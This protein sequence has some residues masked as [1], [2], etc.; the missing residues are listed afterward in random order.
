MCICFYFPDF[1]SYHYTAIN[2]ATLSQILVQN[3]IR[4][5]RRKHSDFDSDYELSVHN[6]IQINQKPNYK[7]LRGEKPTQFNLIGI[8]KRL[9]VVS[10]YEGN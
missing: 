5:F 7:N 3:L 10:N 4:T 2:F 9:Y 8:V 6:L 1:L